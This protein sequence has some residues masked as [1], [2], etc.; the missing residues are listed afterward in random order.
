M[1]FIDWAT[2]IAYVAF[3]LDMLFEIRKVLATRDSRDLSIPGMSIR[4]F[5]AAL[6]LAKFTYIQDTY[7][8]IG[9]TIFVTTI[10]IYLILLVKYR[11]KK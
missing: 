8:I 9:Q 5:A 4:L 11:R 3:N 10:L 1:N 7:L 2:F 6:L